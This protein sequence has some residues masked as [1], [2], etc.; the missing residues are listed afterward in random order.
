MNPGGGGG[1]VTNTHTCKWCYW[2]AQIAWACR[3]KFHLF[4]Q[5]MAFH[6]VFP[7]MMFHAVGKQLGVVRLVLKYEI[8]P[9]M[10][11]M[12]SCRKKRENLITLTTKKKHVFKVTSGVLTFYLRNIWETKQMCIF[13]CLYVCVLG[14]PLLTQ[15][16]LSG[17]LQGCYAMPLMWNTTVKTTQ[18]WQRKSEQKTGISGLV[19]GHKVPVHILFNLWLMTSTKHQVV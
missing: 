3:K 18:G 2:R 13:S 12:E 17:S 1:F 6:L 7:W 10:F 14:I 4:P 16:V 11:S 15:C 5:S 19:T 8:I 9:S